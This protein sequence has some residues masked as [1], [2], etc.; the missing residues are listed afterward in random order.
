MDIEILFQEN[1][2]AKKEILEFCRLKK[3][4]KLGESATKAIEKGYFTRVAIITLD[5]NVIP[6]DSEPEAIAEKVWLRTKSLYEEKWYDREDVTK[7][8]P[9]GYKMRDLFDGDMIKL[10]SGIMLI[11]TEDGMVRMFA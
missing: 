11:S 4:G 6:K 10:E 8:H 5:E 3:F 9:E 2:K 1:Y 7:S